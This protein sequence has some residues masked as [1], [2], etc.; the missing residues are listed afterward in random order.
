MIKKVAF[1]WYVTCHDYFLLFDFVGLTYCAC[2]EPTYTTID[3]GEELNPLRE[4]FMLNSQATAHVW[5][6]NTLYG[7]GDFNC[8]IDQFNNTM[9]Y[10]DDGIKCLLHGV[11]HVIQYHEWRV[12]ETD[13]WVRCRDI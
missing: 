7:L 1:P 8:C 12:N 9:C 11:K 3:V 4:S 6:F 10:T 5:R 2:W 13:N